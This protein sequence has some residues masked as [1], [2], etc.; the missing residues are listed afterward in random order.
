GAKRPSPLP[1]RVHY[2]M[3]PIAAETA[4]N[5]RETEQVILGRVL[6]AFYDHPI[7]RGHDLRDDFVGTDTVLHVRLEPLSLQDIYD[8]W[9]ALRGPYRLSVSY[10]VSVVKIDSGAQP[11][12]ASP[13]TVVQ[14]E[15]AQIVGT[16]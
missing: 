9:D 7:L 6:Q 1:L 4:L 10:E 12:P 13:V 14:P 11:T 5:G 3:T 15:Y 16:E 8:L 2:L